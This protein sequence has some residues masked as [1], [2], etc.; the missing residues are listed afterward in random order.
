MI[1]KLDVTDEAILNL[2]IAP[3]MIND[4]CQPVP[5]EARNHHEMY[6][7]TRSMLVQQVSS[8]LPEGALEKYLF[9][10]DTPSLR[11]A[12]RKVARNPRAYPLSY[13]LVGIKWLFKR[14]VSRF[15]RRS[16]LGQSNRRP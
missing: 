16:N 3:V 6:Q 15:R 5:V 10:D 8:S 13:Y 14:L 12:V 11:D 7:S 9:V 1:L 4:M 2:D